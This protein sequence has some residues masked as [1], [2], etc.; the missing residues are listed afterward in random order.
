MHIL[1]VDDDFSMLK[2]I[3]R[4]L[5]RHV[6]FIAQDS[7]S[8]VRIA[9]NKK[10]DAIVLDVFLGQENGIEIIARLMQA[11][12]SSSI[13]VVCGY[14]TQKLVNDAYGAGACAFIDKI[15]IGLLNEILSSLFP[16]HGRGR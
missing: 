1:I 6:T 11:S 9:A 7:A 14:P 13:I 5:A 8:A 10:P 12:P 16:Q 2:V 3:R 4:E 15:D